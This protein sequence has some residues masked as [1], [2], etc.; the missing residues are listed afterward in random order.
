LLYYRVRLAKESY[1]NK[2]QAIS[3]WLDLQRKFPEKIITIHPLSNG[4][5][6]IKVQ[7]EE[8]RGVRTVFHLWQLDD[9]D[10][11]LRYVFKVA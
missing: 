3:L 8:W 9:Y 10:Q 4:D 7:E 5:W 1:M 11:F 6:Y 2:L